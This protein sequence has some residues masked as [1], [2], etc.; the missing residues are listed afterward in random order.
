MTAPLAH[1]IGTQCAS[2]VPSTPLEKGLV[3][4]AL[5]FFAVAAVFAI[6]THFYDDEAHRHRVFHSVKK[7]GFCSR[8]IREVDAE[9]QDKQMNS[10]ALRGPLALST[11]RERA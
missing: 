8:C 10:A 7:S 4:G 2:I 5:F 3:G 6:W 11:R 1:C 9:Y